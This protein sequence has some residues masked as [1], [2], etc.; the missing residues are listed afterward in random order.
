MTK[1]FKF[2]TPGD[3]FLARNA[4]VQIVPEARCEHDQAAFFLVLFGRHRSEAAA[5]DQRLH[6]LMPRCVLAEAI[7][8]L[9]AHILHA[10][11]E[12][13]LK[14]FLDEAAAHATV[15]LAGLEQLHAE[16]R[17]CCEAGFRTNGSEHTCGRNED[18]Q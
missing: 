1:Q 8:A 9:Q 10:E 2:F 12:G 3:Y 11:G 4:G 18:Q 16:G 7:G 14:E 5:A 13:A 6:T 15:S 17:D